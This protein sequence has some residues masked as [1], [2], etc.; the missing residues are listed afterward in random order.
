[1]E[2]LGAC[3]ISMF[4]DANSRSFK[5]SSA[6]SV[7]EA[8]FDWKSSLTDSLGGPRLV[9]TEKCDRKNC[10]ELNVNEHKNMISIYKYS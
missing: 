9:I 10:N 3:S 4:L 7:S 2:D 1:M 8:C 6:L 5:S